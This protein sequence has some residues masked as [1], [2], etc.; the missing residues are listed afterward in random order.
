MYVPSVLAACCYNAIIYV[1]T[2]DSTD[3]G[4]AT[5]IVETFFA[6]QIPVTTASFGSHSF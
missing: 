3:Y 4:I 6:N 2:E 5:I 1:D